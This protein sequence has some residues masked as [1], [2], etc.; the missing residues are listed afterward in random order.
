[1]LR[2]KKKCSPVWFKPLFFRSLKMQLN[3][4]LNSQRVEP[5]KPF[6]HF[7]HILVML[8][9]YPDPIPT[10][11]CCV[12]VCVCVCSRP[13]FGTRQLCCLDPAV[14]SAAMPVSLA[15]S[16]FSPLWELS[17]EWNPLRM[18]FL[19]ASRHS[20]MNFPFGIPVPRTLF[21]EVL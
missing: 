12:C 7:P 2:E 20:R 6:C 21:S 18:T 19:R 3:A 16:L 1:M 11:P 13:I 14:S 10:C 15:T 4:T 5:S 8:G 17:A 9:Y